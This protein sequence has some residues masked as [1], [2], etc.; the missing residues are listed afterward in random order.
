MIL[1]PWA[2]LTHKRLLA[3]GVAAEAW[4]ADGQLVS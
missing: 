1:L 4:A 3:A 2:E